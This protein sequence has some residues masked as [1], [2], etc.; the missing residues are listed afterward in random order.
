M[1]SVGRNRRVSDEEL[2]EVLNE[3]ETP[4][5]SASM[6]AEEVALSRDQTYRR[7]RGLREE[8]RVERLKVGGRAVVWWPVED[9]E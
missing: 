1:G 9:E 3:A 5:L 8:G 4:V 2:L 7:L 6:I